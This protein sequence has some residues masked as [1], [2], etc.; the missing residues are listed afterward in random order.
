MKEAW[1]DVSLFKC[2]YCRTFYAEC[3]WYA[4]ELG[5]DVTC[6]KCKQDFNAK[7][8]IIDRVLLRILVNESERIGDVRISKRIK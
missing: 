7:K 1:L 2:P 8:A 5:S 6:G 3:S 4:A